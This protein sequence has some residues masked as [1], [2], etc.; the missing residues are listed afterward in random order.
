M[1][2][3]WPVLIVSPDR[4]NCRTIAS[5]LDGWGLDILCAA[6]VA[7]ARRILL[8]RSVSMVFSEDCLSDGNYRDVL[9]AAKLGNPSA[10]VVVTSR[11]FDPDFY[12]QSS[13]APPGTVEVIPCPCYLSDV[14][15]A[16]VHAMR[17]APLTAQAARAE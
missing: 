16:I 13:V 6:T 10:H 12:K 14:Q 15:W 2:V 1:K 17:K 3:S 5:I 4:E 11:R 7:H 8:Q 9:R